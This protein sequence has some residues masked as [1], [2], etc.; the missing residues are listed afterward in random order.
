[1]LLQILVRL[2]CARA[3][4]LTSSLSR[5][6]RGLWRHLFALSFCEIPLDAVDAAL[7]RSPALLYLAS[8]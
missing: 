2:R 6:W 3:A 8:Q 4:A 1:M 5:R 7:N